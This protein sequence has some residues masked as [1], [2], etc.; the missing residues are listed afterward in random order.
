[1]QHKQLRNNV[2]TS[3]LL[4]VL[5]SAHLIVCC[6]FDPPEHLGACLLMLPGLIW[7]HM[8]TVLPNGALAPSETRYLVIYA[9]H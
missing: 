4:V 6:I 7:Q 9:S 5:C 8:I 2:L 3:L 1:M